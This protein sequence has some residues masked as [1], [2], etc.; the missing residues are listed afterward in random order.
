[1]ER[2]IQLLVALL[3]LLRVLLELPD[4]IRWRGRNKGNG[5]RKN[6]RKK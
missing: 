6:R 5:Y 2:W 1:M 4:R 3:S